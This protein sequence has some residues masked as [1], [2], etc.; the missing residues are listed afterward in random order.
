MLPWCVWTG[1]H[2]LHILPYHR[3]F[4][5]SP[6]QKT[7][8]DASMKRTGQLDSEPKVDQKDKRGKGRPRSCTRIVGPRIRDTVPSANLCQSTGGRQHKPCYLMSPKS[9]LC[10]WVDKMA[11]EELHKEANISTSEGAVALCTKPKTP[12]AKKAKVTYHADKNDY[13]CKY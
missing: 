4:V 9:T 5:S 10:S 7:P 1:F 8:H 3:G 2:A 13:S 6:I 11:V 12:L